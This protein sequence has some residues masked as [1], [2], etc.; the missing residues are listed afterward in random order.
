[1]FTFM[2][3]NPMLI[4]KNSLFSIITFSIQLGLTPQQINSSIAQGEE[5]L[6]EMQLRNFFTP[7]VQLIFIWMNP[8]F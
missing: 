3:L 4:K 6:S 2:L 1:M 8:K 5:D 7:E